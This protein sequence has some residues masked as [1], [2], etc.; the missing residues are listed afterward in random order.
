MKTVDYF[1]DIKQ[2]LKAKGA[3]DDWLNPPA[4]QQAI[5]EAEQEM[6]LSLPDDWRLLYMRHDG[7]SGHLGLFLGLPW[8]PLKDVVAQWKN[9]KSLE[10]D[11]SEE[12][13]HFSLPWAAIQERYI[14]PGWVPLSHDWGGNHLGVD[15]APGPR[16]QVG[17]IINFGR[18]E[19]LKVVLAW[20]TQD[21]FRFL[22]EEIG[23]DR[24]RLEEPG[25]PMSWCDGAS[26]PGEMT[27][28]SLP[29]YQARLS[30]PRPNDLGA[31][32]SSL[33]SPWPS[34]IGDP[35]QFLTNRLQY[36]IRKDLTEI[37]PVAW[38]FEMVALYIARNEVRD[39][40]PLSNLT[41]LQLIHAVGNPIEDLRPLEGLPGLRV[42]LLDDSQVRDLS[43]LARLPRLDE[44]SLSGAPVQDV[45]P[46]ADATALRNLSVDGQALDLRPLS[47]LRSLSLSKADATTLRTGP[48][49]PRLEN[50][51]IEPAGGISLEC[52][53][54]CRN[55]RRLTLRGVQGGDMSW[56]A[57]VQHL[58]TLTLSDCRL[59]DLRGLRNH[60]R[61]R[62]FN[63]RDSEVADLSALT[64][65]SALST[66]HGNY[67]QF[68]YLHDKVSPRVAF[69]S[70]T[71]GMTEEEHTNWMNILQA[72][73][74]G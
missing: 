30:P 5:S 49:L 6:G 53:Q 1:E 60:P 43:P 47:N 36:L 58:D 56:L 61:L 15:M 2:T 38:C 33:P 21:L 67:A 18:D 74:G 24:C 51:E 41:N 14:N 72:R 13:N 11:Y 45:S 68:A 9:W 20:N 66:V 28:M 32:K 40:S 55:L 16:G 19:D 34:L 63:T 57:G 3:P 42:L 54:A 4:T 10:D 27:R 29:L 59:P 70:I 50:L 7:E 39:L 62:V 23:S 37:G 31:W 64:S 26:L 73:Q 69:N 65:C 22:S 48:E 12:G 52:L 46:L 44:L 35:E 71:G 25:E 8:L 17:Q